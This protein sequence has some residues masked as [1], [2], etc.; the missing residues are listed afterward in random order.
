MTTWDDDANFHRSGNGETLVLL[1]GITSSWHGWKPVIPALA[2]E[3]DVVALTLPG[4]LGWPWPDGTPYTIAALADLVV[5]RLAELGVEKPHVAGNSLGGWI[6]LEMI[7]RGLARSV[8]AFSPAG[9]WA[10]PHDI[11][12]FFLPG[13]ARIAELRESA[14]EILADPERRKRLMAPYLENGDRIAPDEA[15]RAWDAVLA[16]ELL[17][18]LLGPF[19]EPVRTP[20]ADDLPVSIVWG[21]QEKLL[22][23]FFGAPGWH[24]SAP[25]AV[26]S[27]LETGHMPMYD[28]PEAVVTEIRNTTAR[29]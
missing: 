4:H 23:E 12:P 26:W 8:T 22:P 6:G 20:V 19:E 16:V 3:Y 13:Q 17:P 1:H 11:A 14:D 28:D 29:A 18:E 21:N 5:A 27:H 10:G 24:E 7:A 2:E 9:G 15:V 25:G